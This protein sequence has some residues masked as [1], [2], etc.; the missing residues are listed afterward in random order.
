MRSAGK[1]RDFRGGA[2]Y[3]FVYSFATRPVTCINTFAKTE[4]A[5]KEL[6]G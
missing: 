6:E 5:H 1:E 3:L 4:N 2:N